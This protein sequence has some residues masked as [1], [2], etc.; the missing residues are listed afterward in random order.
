M[1]G[2]FLFAVRNA[3]WLLG[4]LLLTFFSSFG[5]TFFISLFSGEIRAAFDLSDGEFGAIYMAG[6]LASAVTL[7]KLGKTLDRFSISAV[8]LCVICALAI[9]C[10]GMSFVNSWMLLLVVIYAL[11]LFGQGMMTH[12][13]QTAIGRWYDADRG[14]AI[15]LTSMGHQ[16]GE[17]LFPAIVL[18]LLGLYDWR[19]AWQI[20]AVALI[21]VAMP[22]IVLLMRVEHRPSANGHLKAANKT[23][24]WTRGEVVRD[25]V[26]WILCLGILAPAFIGTSV[27]FHQVR[28]V[29]SKGWSSNVFALS[30][31]ILSVTTVLFTLI[32]GQLVDRYHARRILPVFLLPLGVACLVLGLGRDPSA[33]YGFMFL[34]AI[35]YGF[36]SAIF[37]TIWP[38]TYGTAHLGSIRAVAVAAMVF[39]S[40]IGPGITGWCI[41]RG[42]G[43]DF[44]LLVMAGY[45][46]FAAVAMIA[47]VKILEGR[48]RGVSLRND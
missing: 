47:A 31:L 15:S 12:T 26:F 18:V 9:A 13:S 29:E 22:S 44:Q 45:C 38:E 41:D 21:V 7:I 14:R 3:R 30:F 1:Q 33:I 16:I 25:G 36:S 10:L 35:S 2:I 19:V 28:I 42:I 40:A 34:L 37:G 39:A 6:T 5:Q 4:G 24:D 27:F 48:Q 46:L 20:C 11:R 23:R 17:A 32:A 8:S 43:F